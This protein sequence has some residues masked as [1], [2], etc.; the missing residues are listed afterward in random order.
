MGAP[1]HDSG[2]QCSKLGLLLN[3]TMLLLLLLLALQVTLLD[4][5]RKRC[6]FLQEAA[7][8]L[9]ERGAGTAA[10]CWEGRGDCGYGA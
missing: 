8:R 9:G 1:R 2:T 3:L 7:R 4:S 10:A 5:L 6:D